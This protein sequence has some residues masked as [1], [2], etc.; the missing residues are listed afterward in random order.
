[1]NQ[2][3][4]VTIE[5]TD[6]NTNTTYSAGSGLSLSGTTFNH[7]S[8]VTA[9]TAGTSSATSGST[10]AVPYVTVNATGHVT[11][12]G[13]HTHTISGFAASSHSH[14]SLTCNYNGGVKSNPQEYFSNTIG[15][16][17]AMTGHW[18]QWSDTLWV[19]GYSGGD[20]KSMCALHFLRNGTPRMGISTQQNT[21]TSYGTIY[22]VITGYNIA[23]QSVNYANSAGS[24][25]WGNI[26][27]KPSTFAPSSHNH[28]YLRGGPDNRSTN[29]SPSWYMTN[30]GAA[31][32]YTEFC[33]SGGANGNFENRTTFIPWGDQSGQRP[34]QL[35]FNNSGMFIRTAASDTAWNGWSGFSLAGHTHNYVPNNT[36]STITG[37]GSYLIIGQTGGWGSGT[38]AARK[39]RLGLGTVGHT[40]SQYWTFCVD[41]TTTNSYL[42]IG[43]DTSTTALSIRHDGLVNVTSLAIGG[44]TIT[45]TT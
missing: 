13:T 12:Y 8:S 23:N 34:V 38:S 36:G 9:G 10:L 39:L 4:N 15:L 33:Q 40:G 28:S 6:S 3:S 30:L 24:V 45:F 31:S 42:Q 18:S 5:L 37:H 22:E 44:Q 43:Y 17:V 11:G 27:G 14:S 7:A 25:A 20:V 19:N 26:T 41:D 29:N 21:A 35:A 2:S 32:I 16:K 1:L